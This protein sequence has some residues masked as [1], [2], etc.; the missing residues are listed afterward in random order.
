VKPYYQHA[1]ITIYHGDCRE[2]MRQYLRSAVDVVIADPPYGDTS[3][4]WDRYVSGWA[5][6]ARK[7][8]DLQGSMWV[9]GSFRFFF[10]CGDEFEGW[11]LAQDVIWEKQNGSS[12]HADRFKRVHEHAVQFYRGEWANIYKQPVHTWGHQAKVTRRK[13]RPPHTG[14]IKAAAYIAEDGGPRL[15]TSV[16]RMRNCHGYAEHP[17]QK[18]LGICDPLL[19]YSCKPTGVVLEPFMGSGSG[20]MAAKR[21]GLRAIGIEIEEKYCEIAAK[22]LSQEVLNFSES[23]TT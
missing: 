22:R 1:G 5:Q 18:P 21:L 23:E 2:V 3:L 9:F 20:V 19:Q 12:F 6:V 16:I 11:R 4:D 8:L 13:T 10:E 14:N 17:T 15:M 7:V